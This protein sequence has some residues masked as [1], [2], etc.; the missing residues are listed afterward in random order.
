MTTSP[1]CWWMVNR[2]CETWSILRTLQNTDTGLTSEGSQ[3]LIATVSSADGTVTI[4][5]FFNGD[6]YDS[7]IPRFHKETDLIEYKKSPI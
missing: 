6:H 7:L 1:K 2:V 3:Q 5:I 4:N